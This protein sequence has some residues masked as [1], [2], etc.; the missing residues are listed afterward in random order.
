LWI[1]TFLPR[2]LSCPTGSQYAAPTG[3]DMNRVSTAF[4]GQVS[5]ASRPCNRQAEG[6]RPRDQR[7][8]LHA[9]REQPSR[10]VAPM[11]RPWSRSSSTRDSDPDA[12]HHAMQ[13]NPL[14]TAALLQ[15]RPGGRIA[16]PA[17]SCGRQTRLRRRS[18]ACRRHHREGAR[19]RARP[20]QDRP[21]VGGGPRRASI[22]G[23][24]A[25]GGVLSLLG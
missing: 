9:A 3:A 24:D 5:A 10:A 23:S 7:S 18:A 20:H 11:S 12:R 14:Y 21:A 15:S 19:A 22:R 25:A 1:L 8:G 16:R 13:R 2:E 6:P 4:V 17:G